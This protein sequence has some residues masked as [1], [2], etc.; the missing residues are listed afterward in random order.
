[1]VLND[2]EDQL[3]TMAEMERADAILQEVY[4][5]A[6]AVGGYRC[7]FYPGPHKFGLENAGRGIRL[8]QSV[9]EG[10]TT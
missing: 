6:G 2:I 7:F 10:I 4:E 8:V 1:M 9:A 3:F 5:K